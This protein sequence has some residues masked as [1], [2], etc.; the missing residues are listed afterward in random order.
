MHPQDTRMLEMLTGC[1]VLL[2]TR[3]EWT[4]TGP[5]A[6]VPKSLDSSSNMESAQVAA[7]TGAAAARP[8]SRTKQ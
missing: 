3:N 7:L 6:T 8:A 5:R 4:W 1:C 2:T